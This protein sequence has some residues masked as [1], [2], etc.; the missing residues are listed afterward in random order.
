MRAASV[1]VSSGLSADW[2]AL[3]D[4]VRV[5]ALTLEHPW[6]I[7]GAGVIALGITLWIARG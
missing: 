2:P 1:V 4:P 3:F 7:L 6:L 5:E